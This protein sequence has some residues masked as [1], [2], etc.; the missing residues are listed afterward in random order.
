MVDVDEANSSA[1]PDIWI[2][3]VQ[4]TWSD[5]CIDESAGFEVMPNGTLRPKKLGRYVRKLKM[6]LI[7]DEEEKKN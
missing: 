1:K 4:Y 3:G 5:V 6:R 7:K 2:D